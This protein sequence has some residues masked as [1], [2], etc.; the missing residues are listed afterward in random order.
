MTIAMENELRPDWA[1]P[2][3]EPRV[4]SV[5][6]PTMSAH[7]SPGFVDQ[8][9]IELVAA[10]DRF[11]QTVIELNAYTAPWRTDDVPH[12]QL[13]VRLRSKRERAD[14]GLVF[15]APPEL[16]GVPYR[17]FFDRDAFEE[18]PTNPHSCGI[19]TADFDE[20]WAIVCRLLRDLEPLEVRFSFGA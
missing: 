14:I 9:V 1:I 17:R 18:D 10:L 3:S 16:P 11:R 8:V 6:G 13:T 15:G 20:C 12:G 7:F 4:L 2:R 5:D 19:F